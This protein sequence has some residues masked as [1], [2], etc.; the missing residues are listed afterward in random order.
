M[1]SRA[2]RSSRSPRRSFKSRRI[3]FAFSEDT[4]RSD[5]S[6]P[7][8]NT[9]PGRLPVSGLP[10]TARKT[11]HTARR[12]ERRIVHDGLRCGLLDSPESE[13][14]NRMRAI[15]P[16][17]N[18]KPKTPKNTYASVSPQHEI[19]QTGGWNRTSVNG[20]RPNRWQPSCQPRQSYL[21]PFDFRNAF[22]F[23]RS[24][25]SPQRRSSSVR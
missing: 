22:N 21:R 25:V 9:E 17:K 15:R 19:V 6:M 2:R 14:A 12:A 11:K 16:K 10:L 18:H 20:R 5:S 4:D 3:G 7:G 23:A 1:E 24:P 8:P 13:R